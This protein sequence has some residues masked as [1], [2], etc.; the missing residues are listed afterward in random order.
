MVEAHWLIAEV[1]RSIVMRR[2]AEVYSGA[3][4]VR[5]V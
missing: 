3:A 2:Q 5:R 1:D 4:E